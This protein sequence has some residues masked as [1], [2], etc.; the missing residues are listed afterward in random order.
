[1][2]DSAELVKSLKDTAR[3]RQA[4]FM[5]EFKQLV[6]SYGALDIKHQKPW[7]FREGVTYLFNG[8]EMRNDDIGNI[9]FGYYGAA[10]YGKGFLHTGAGFYQLLS[11]LRG[12]NPVQWNGK[13]FDDPQ[14]YD[15][16]EYGFQ[17]Y[18]EEHPN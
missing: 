7:M 15:M 2:R 13:F 5:D 12:K 17:L 14:D 10:V 3:S 16:I 6:K 4:N 11:D 9:A 18:L 8:K 1:M